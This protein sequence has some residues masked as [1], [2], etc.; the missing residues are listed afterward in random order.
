MTSFRHGAQPIKTAFFCLLTHDSCATLHGT[1][2]QHLGSGP[3]YFL[4]KDGFGSLTTKRKVCAPEGNLLAWAREHGVTVTPCQHCLRGRRITLTGLSR[5]QAPLLA[6]AETTAAVEGLA[7]EVRRLARGRNA[8]L[9]IAALKR[10]RSTCEA[11][12]T[13]FSRILGGD[14][15]HA[16]QVHHRKQLALSR[17]PRLTKLNELAVLCANCHSF[18]HINRMRSL[19]IEKLKALL[20]S[21]PTRS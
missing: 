2:C 21:Q 6:S 1:R 14:G 19:S 5:A 13:D 3:P 4:L 16:L 7:R 17:V 18:I 9:R 12:S 8:R 15:V 11:C 20:N 10:A